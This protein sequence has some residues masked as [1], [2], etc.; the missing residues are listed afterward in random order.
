MGRVK[1]PEE[2]FSINLLKPIKKLSLKIEKYEDH[3]CRIFLG[4]QEPTSLRR[5]QN[6]QNTLKYDQKHHFYATILARRRQIGPRR[7]QTLKY[8]EPRSPDPGVS[9]GML[10][11]Q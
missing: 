1:T 6:D 4:R 11:I 5:R 8:E 7:R 10:H 3:S 2:I 9:T